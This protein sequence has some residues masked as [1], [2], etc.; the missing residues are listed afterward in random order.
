MKKIITT[1][2]LFLITLSTA[3]ACR[4]IM[5]DAKLFYFMDAKYVFRAEVETA[6]DC[7]D[8]N[9]YEYTLEVEKIYKGELKDEITIYSD[10][11]TSCAFQLEAGKTYLFFTDLINDNLGFCEYRLSKGSPD[12]KATLNYLDLIKN[13]NLD[14]L[15][16]KDG[17]NQPLGDI[18]VVDG[19]V[20]GVVKLY[21]P[22]GSIR[23]RGLY[24]KGVPHG[25][26]EITEKMQTNTEKW[27]GDYKNGQRTGRWIRIF[28]KNET[29]LHE[30]IFY[31]DGEIVDRYVVNL[32]SQLE[33]FTP[34]KKKEEKK[35]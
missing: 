31:E 15:K 12:F 4:C 6:S 11:I 17:K 23:L 16:I 29:T 8:N 10:C 3:S 26:F 33:R 18:Q 1:L 5:D 21:F 22:D 28:K 19:H 32:K 2:A 9:K 35:Q 24:M 14:F 27:A 30:H 7:G 25:N 34:E 20:D 13:T